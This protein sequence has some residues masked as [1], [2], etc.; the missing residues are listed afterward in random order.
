MAVVSLLLLLLLGATLSSCVLASPF[1]PVITNWTGSPGVGP[2]LSRRLA[3][4]SFCLH[5]SLNL[6]VCAADTVSV[7]VSQYGLWGGP[8]DSAGL[9]EVEIEYG[10]CS[11][12]LF[13]FG[14][15]AGWPAAGATEAVTVGGKRVAVGVTAESIA[16]VSGEFCFDRATLDVRVDG[17]VV[18]SPG[19]GLGVLD[20]VP[21]L[22]SPGLFCDGTRGDAG[23][24]LLKKKNKRRHSLGLGPLSRLRPFSF[25]RSSY[26]LPSGAAS[27]PPN[28][29]PFV[30]LSPPA[31]SS[32][33]GY[34]FVGCDH[35]PLGAVFVRVECAY[36]WFSC[37]TPPSGAP[38]FRWREVLTDMR[39]VSNLTVDEVR[40]GKHRTTASFQVLNV[41]AQDP[42]SLDS[43]CQARFYQAATMYRPNEVLQSVSSGALLPEEW[44]YLADLT[45]TSVFE[46]AKDAPCL[47]STISVS[48]TNGSAVV[49]PASAD[50]HCFPIGCAAEIPTATP[51]PTPTREPRKS[52]TGS[53]LRIALGAATGAGAI[54]LIVSAW[55]VTMRIKR[56]RLD[57][58]RAPLL[59]S[60]PM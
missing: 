40:K 36:E 60:L 46:D 8:A 51:T 25:P 33:N 43:M 52:L 38:C 49:F 5:P 48:A 32:V 9:F 10:G 37:A 6:T 28:P 53:S 24:R 4:L 47:C 1:S 59:T 31:N 23:H 29:P 45:F 7:S 21:V 12:L 27:R 30:P 11:R 14:A 34:N 41:F 35:L 16:V 50:L 2:G 15:E 17:A 18:V 55:F 42:R 39:R 22:S 13:A 56:N 3:S 44:P 54:L 20:R 26:L 57:K 19:D 58:A